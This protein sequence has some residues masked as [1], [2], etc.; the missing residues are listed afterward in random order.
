MESW[1]RTGEARAGALDGNTV[2]EE[3]E[4][5]VGMHVLLVD[6]DQDT[7]DLLKAALVNWQ[8]R[9]TAV[10]SAGEALEV[11][12]VTT[13]DVLISDIAMPESDGYELLQQVRALNHGNR[14]FVPAVA[15]TAYAR[16]EDR[17]RALSSGFQGYVAKPVEIS[18]LFSAVAE[19]AKKCQP[20]SGN[21]Q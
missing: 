11:F 3:Y 13:P 2:P 18:E 21:K 14:R 12:R 4:E 6:D 7:L 20:T 9:V 15:I 1:T 10:K 8:V 17:Q 5:L 19:A 16:E